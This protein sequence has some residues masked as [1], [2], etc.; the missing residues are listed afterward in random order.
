MEKLNNIVPI[1]VHYDFNNRNFEIKNYLIELD[2][3]FNKVI[4]VENNPSDSLRLLCDKISSVSYI[5][6]ANRAGLAGAYNSAIDYVKDFLFGTEYILFLDD[7]TNIFDLNLNDY[8]EKLISIQKKTGAAAIA[9][10]YQDVNSGTLCNFLR[11]DRWR[12]ERVVDRGLVEKVTFIINSMSIWQL[13]DLL[14]LGKFNE[15]LMI[16]HIDSEMCLRAYERGLVIN[17]DYSLIFNHQIGKRLKYSIFGMNLNSGNH[18][19]GRRYMI[20]RATAYLFRSRFQSWPAVSLLMA[21]R[22]IYEILGI[23][24]VEK[25]KFQKVLAFA[26]GFYCGFIKHYKSIK[27]YEAKNNS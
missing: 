8:V 17:A 26:K 14:L 25:N 27:N 13:K 11:L 1:I 3:L 20:G 2:K 5:H 24:V 12:C 23:I 21:Q 10:R 4:L 19:V 16:D 18:A 9:G 15:E 7:D 22:A 6:N